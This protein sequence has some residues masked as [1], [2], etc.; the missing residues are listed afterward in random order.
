MSPHGL[1]H[2]SVIH[3]R[4][5]SF[6]VLFVLLCMASSMG[7][8]NRLLFGKRVILNNAV[9]KS[10][11]IDVDAS[12]LHLL[13]SVGM[14][15]KSAA[16][17]SV[18]VDGFADN[19]GVEKN[20]LQL[21]EDR[22]RSVKKYLVQKYRIESDRII[23]KGFGSGSPIG[24]NNT[25]EG[26]SLNRR[27]EVVPLTP[28]TKRPVVSVYDKPINEEGHISFLQQEVTTK[29]PWTPLFDDA[30]L[31][32]PVYELHKIRTLAD[33]RSVV[34][35]NDF[36]EMKIG[37]NT[38]IIIYGSPL[39]EHHAGHKDDV[40]LMTGGL[41]AKLRSLSPD[42]RFVV[43]TPAASVAM[44]NETSSNL[45]IDR[46]GRLVVSV[47]NGEADVAAQNKVVTV[48]AGFGTDVLKG[49]A[50]AAPRP[51]P[52]SPERVLPDYDSIMN[53]SPSILFRW[54][55]PT[56]RTRVEVSSDTVFNSIVSSSTVTDSSVSVPLRPSKYYYRYVAIDSAG[57]E[58]K[59]DK[60][61]SLVVFDSSSNHAYLEVT[62]P[63]GRRTTVSG[64]YYDITGVAESGSRVTINGVA[65]TPKSN[66]SFAYRVPL[67][68]GDNI[69][70]LRARD[71]K[72]R[73]AEIPVTIR[74]T[75][76]HKPYTLSFRISFLS[77]FQNYES[78]NSGD[79]FTLSDEFPWKENLSVGITAGVGTI[80][81]K[82]SPSV[83]GNVASASGPTIWIVHGFVKSDIVS[84]DPITC[85]W[86]AGCGLIGC[87]GQGQTALGEYA[88]TY[89][90]GLS[91]RTNDR[92]IGFVLG[93]Q[94]I[95]IVNDYAR[96]DAFSSETGHS[97]ISF[98]AGLIV[99][100]L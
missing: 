36:S 45:N 94:Y 52:L 54:K 31:N 100:G 37:G 29:P 70:I 9:F 73:S 66:S 56:S 3:T 32:E 2:R 75:I 92:P 60:Y 10:A 63:Q 90:V 1:R 40:E 25:E 8:V 44:K 33:S 62:K 4:S 95:G 35:F 80:T 99:S 86:D 68:D 53:S 49:S 12:K 41:L 96:F 6:V 27:V 23:V 89:E 83:V 91:V 15:L 5:T 28:L 22:A 87:T 20:N 58:S 46:S 39:S 64:P 13:D 16:D 21:S 76:L 57:R 42:R 14:L 67:G 85:S 48:T 11:D 38:M 18:E 77:D 84:A 71:L 24:D 61:Y 74:R 93:L 97:F 43:N 26:R 79:L 98:G 50:P 55:S 65:I 82:A 47:F 88:M 34:T 7:Q 69:F 30:Y 19:T 51:L 72:G 59:P 17:M 78:F 81:L